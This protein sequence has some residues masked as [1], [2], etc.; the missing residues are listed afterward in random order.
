MRKFLLLLPCLYAVVTTEGQGKK[1][2]T[3]IIAAISNAHTAKPCGSFS[4]LFTKEM[5]PGLEVGAG[6]NWSS[7]PKHDWFQE[8]RF[9][10]FYHRYVQHSLSFYTDFGYRYKLPLDMALEARAGGGFTRVI[11]A[12]E[13]FVD[14][15]DEGKQ[16][17]KIVSG[18]SQVIVTTSLAL[19]KVISKKSGSRIFF[20]YQ[21]RVLT[22]FVQSYIPLLPY[23]IAMIGA[24]FPIRSNHQKN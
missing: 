17:T 11:V 12:N 22:P 24:N 10:Y 13:V 9:G 21:Q 15:M 3:Y 19:N 1:K 18:R 8:L 20:Q 2:Q 7:K 16:Y 14:G 23:N 6:I 5:H 4:A